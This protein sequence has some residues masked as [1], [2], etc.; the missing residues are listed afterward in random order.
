[1]LTGSIFESE[2][3]KVAS[4]FIKP[5]TTVL[6]VGENFGQMSIAFSKMQNDVKIYSFEAQPFV[7]EYL[8]KTIA[9]NQ[10]NAEIIDCPVWYIENEK[11]EFSYWN[12]NQN[13]SSS[14]VSK[15]QS[16]HSLTTITID[17]LNIKEPISFMKVDIQ[18]ADLFGM[19][20]AKETILKNKMPILFEYEEDGQHHFNTSF[21]NYVEFV[22]SINY[23]F[24]RTINE[25]N[26]LIIPK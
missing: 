23:K 12:E 21:N 20:G 8:K 9:N 6:D 18:G 5:Q 26:Y 10:V 2:V 25:I 16:D 13:P 17:S 24:S 15:K 22:E 1:M 11:M 4:D 7:L 19:M 14:F 3:L